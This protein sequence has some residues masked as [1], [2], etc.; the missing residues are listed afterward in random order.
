MFK[1]ATKRMNWM[2]KVLIIQSSKFW[3]FTRKQTGL[4]NGFVLNKGIKQGLVLRKSVW[5]CEVWV[6]EKQDWWQGDLAYIIS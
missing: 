1:G 3:I 4:Q 2:V 6:K 5:Q